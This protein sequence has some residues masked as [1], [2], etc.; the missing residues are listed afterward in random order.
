MN[1]TNRRRERRKLIGMFAENRSALLLIALFVL[2]M[3]WGCAAAKNCSEEFGGVLE[4]LL[5]SFT[6]NRAEHSFFSVVLSGAFPALILVSV[7][8]LSGLSPVGF[9]LAAAAPLFRGVGLGVVS[10]YLYNTCGLKGT[11]FCVLT[12]Y[13]P[14]VFSVTALVLCCLEA[15]RMSLGFA[16]LLHRGAAGGVFAPEVKLY[17]ARFA[18]FA[19]IIL[20]SCVFDAFLNKAFCGFFQF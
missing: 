6:L 5:S 19:G 2:G 13:P 10:G 4:K 9:P 18:V 15:C 12:V 11:A 14:A 16:S 7:V 3:L 1:R 8:F 17:I 20:F